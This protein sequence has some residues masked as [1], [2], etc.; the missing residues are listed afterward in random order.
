MLFNKSLIRLLYRLLCCYRS[1]YFWCDISIALSK[2]IG[3]LVLESSC[4]RLLS[5]HHEPEKSQ[6]HIPTSCGL[7]CMGR[8]RKTCPSMVND[9]K[10]VFFFKSS[11]GMLRVGFSTYYRHFPRNHPLCLSIFIVVV[12]LKTDV[13]CGRTD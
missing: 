8:V 9:K 6:K 3:V 10:M 2:Y 4:Q 13:D 1:H 7:D 11:C 5:N 12:E